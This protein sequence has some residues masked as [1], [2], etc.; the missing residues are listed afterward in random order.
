MSKF[1][2]I[3]FSQ[4]IMVQSF[5]A[6]MDNVLRFSNFLEHARF[7]ADSHGDSF[8]GFIEKHYGGQKELHFQEHIEEHEKHEK[9][10]FKEHNHSCLQMAVSFVLNTAV[11]M[12]LI[13][14]FLE[15]PLNFYYKEPI[16]LFEKSSVFQPPK[17]A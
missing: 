2:A 1:V 17:Q 12:P 9:L 16:S 7:H 15:I 3:V 5:N 10:P 13:E 6:D 8:F 4:L 11:E 14:P